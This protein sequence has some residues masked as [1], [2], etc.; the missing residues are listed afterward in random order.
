LNSSPL[1]FEVIG[2]SAKPSSVK[3]GS[4]AVAEQPDLASLGSAPSGFA[5]DPA[6]TGGTLYVKVGPGA[7]SVVVRK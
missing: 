1:L 6:V 3:D 4:V 5:Y 2:F 7:H